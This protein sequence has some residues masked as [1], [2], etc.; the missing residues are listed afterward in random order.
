VNA[1]QKVTYAFLFTYFSNQTT[2]TVS[3]GSLHWRL[4][5]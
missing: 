1:Q 5:G 3:A 2:Y 4:W